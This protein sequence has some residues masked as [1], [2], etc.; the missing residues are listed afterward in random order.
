MKKFDEIEGRRKEKEGRRNES[1]CISND[2]GMP[3]EPEL[4]GLN[5]GK[6]VLIRD[7]HS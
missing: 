4:P 5:P 7:F 6:Y 1:V 2:K 3:S